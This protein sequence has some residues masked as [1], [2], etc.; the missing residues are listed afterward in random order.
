MVPRIPFPKK[1]RHPD[2]LVVDFYCSACGHRSGEWWVNDVRV[3]LPVP[4]ESE[5]VRYVAEHA[6]HLGCEGRIIIA[7]ETLT[8]STPDE[9]GDERP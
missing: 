2:V 5:Y 7:T 1:A 6:T 8:P 4:E 9:G 3:P